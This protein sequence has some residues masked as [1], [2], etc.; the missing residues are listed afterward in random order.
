MRAYQKRFSDQITK[1]NPRKLGRLKLGKNKR[2]IV[3]CGRFDYGGGEWGAFQV[4][5]I[6]GHAEKEA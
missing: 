5:S 3:E 6:E 2:N 1:R 4:I